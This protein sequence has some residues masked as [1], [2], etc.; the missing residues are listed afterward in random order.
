MLGKSFYM[1]GIY[2]GQHFLSLLGICVEDICWR[3]FFKSIGYICW[4]YMLDN[5]FLYML[6]NINVT[7]H[8]RRCYPT[9]MG[10]T[11]NMYA[12]DICRVCVGVHEHNIGCIC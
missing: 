5:N 12:Q 1:L 9:Y 2:V 11:P 6:G 7:Q 4:V 3:T 10:V 8:I